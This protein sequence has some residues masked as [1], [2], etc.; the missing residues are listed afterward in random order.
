MVANQP[1]EGQDK[2]KD[3]PR[4]GLPPTVEV[5]QASAPMQLDATKREDPKGRYIQYN[6]IGTVRQMT[7]ADWKA[8]H[9]DSDKTVEWNY[10]NKKRIPLSAFNDAELHYLL[11]VDDRFS[12][13]SDEPEKPKEAN[14]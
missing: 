4:Q 11:R 10:L 14:E 13:V 8:A 3:D 2:P 5:V 9:V 6:G 1:A 7:P 12:I